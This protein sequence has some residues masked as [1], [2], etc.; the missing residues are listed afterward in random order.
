MN[1]AA[2]IPMTTCISDTFRTGQVTVQAASTLINPTLIVHSHRNR[3][4]V[5]ITNIG[6]SDMYI[7]N[8]NVSTSNGFLLRQG[9]NFT[10]NITTDAIYGITATNPTLVCFWED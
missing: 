6:G 2:A 9:Q 5:S 1:K 10:D 3:N 7:G 8:Q 4:S